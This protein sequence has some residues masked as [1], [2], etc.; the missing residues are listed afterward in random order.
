MCST[1]VLSQD[2]LCSAAAGVL[3]LTFVKVQFCCFFCLLLTVFTV[4]IVGTI[5]RVYSVCAMVNVRPAK[6]KEFC[7]PQKKKSQKC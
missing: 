2:V 4:L 5:P 6:W 1:Y 7:R 3:S